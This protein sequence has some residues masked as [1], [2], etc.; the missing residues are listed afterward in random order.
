MQ[1]MIDTPKN[2]D[3]DAPPGADRLTPLP[4]YRVSDLLRGGREAVL[5]HEGADY[6]LRITAK[7]RLILTK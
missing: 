5:E 4:R 3:R 2:D 1:A 6:R 7:G